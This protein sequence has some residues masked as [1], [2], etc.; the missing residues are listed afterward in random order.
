MDWR[1]QTGSWVIS[2][3]DAWDPDGIRSREWFAG[4]EWSLRRASDDPIAPRVRWSRGSS[5][6]L[7]SWSPEGQGLG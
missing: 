1:H 3:P 7:E 2:Q 5:L 6:H 4:V